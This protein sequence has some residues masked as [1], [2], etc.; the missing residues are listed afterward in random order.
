MN[1]KQQNHS[2]EETNNQVQNKIDHAYEAF[3]DLTVT[4]QTRRYSPELTAMGIASSGLAGAAFGKNSLIPCL[5][6]GGLFLV[7]LTYMWLTKNAD[8]RKNPPT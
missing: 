5:V 6:I 4:P 1:T 3:R 8:H 7:F 2:C